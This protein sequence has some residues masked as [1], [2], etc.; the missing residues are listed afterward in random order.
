MQRLALIVAGGSGS[1]MGSEVPKQFL[2]L[3]DRPLLLHTLGRFLALDAA[4]QLVL[5]LPSAHLSYW[6]KTAAT[7]LPD[8]D[9][10]R[11]RAVAGGDTRTQSVFAGLL[12]LEAIAPADAWVAIHDGVRPFVTP[13]LLRQAYD[14]AATAGAAVACVPVKA[15]LRYQRDDGSSE[16]VDR[17]RYLEV[18][19]PQVFRLDQ[20]I[21]AYRCRPHDAFTDDAGLYEALGGTV[22]PCPGSYDN[23]KV[24][25]PEDMDLAARLLQRFPPGQI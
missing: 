16:T 24:T 13:T 2:R 8:A 15:T 11:I 12:A 1:R 10:A 19:T 4:L 7:T 21:D 5:V 9:R 18:Q 22:M 17:S 25:T 20:I 3:G 23:I 14:T 6:D